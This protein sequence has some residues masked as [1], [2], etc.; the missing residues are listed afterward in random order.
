M[1]GLSSALKVIGE[2]LADP[3]Q[4]AVGKLDVG[5]ATW[6]ALADGCGIEKAGGPGFSREVLREAGL[7]RPP[8]AQGGPW[9]GLQSPGPP[10][11]LPVY[12]SGVPVQV[13]LLGET[14]PVEPVSAPESGGPEHAD[15][16]LSRKTLRAS[17]PRL[18]THGTPNRPRLWVTRKVPR[19][20]G[21]RQEVPWM[22]R[23]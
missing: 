4:T 5:A 2:A 19:A 11:G 12:M 6:R 20:Q 22:W 10:P 17:P 3:S 1:A 7:T 18:S 15:R 14:M 21:T 13:A 9:H 8:W 16:Q 23:R